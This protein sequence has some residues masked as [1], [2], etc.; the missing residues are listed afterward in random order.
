MA[1]FLALEAL[2]IRDTTVSLSLGKLG[3][4]RSPAVPS[5]ITVLG[6]PLSSSSPLPSGAASIVVEGR[7]CV[8]VGAL[9]ASAGGAR[10]IL[11]QAV[12]ASTIAWVTATWARTSF[13]TTTIVT[14]ASA[15][16]AIAVIAATTVACTAA[17]TRAASA[18]SRR[19]KD[20]V[21]GTQSSLRDFG[22]HDALFKRRRFRIQRSEQHVLSDWRSD[23]SPES[24]SQGPIIGFVNERGELAKLVDVLSNGA[25]SLTALL[26]ENPLTFKPVRW[27]A[28]VEHLLDKSIEGPL[29]RIHRYIS[30]PELGCDAGQGRL[31]H[32]NMLCCLDKPGFHVRTRLHAVALEGM[33]IW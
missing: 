23:S 33:N 16:S 12:V 17:A 20:T 19:E 32:L 28:V 24:A 9:L 10:P 5:T 11:V 3:S 15:A 6:L 8:C 22:H 1:S 18:V 31:E 26:K 13:A 21:A 14:S 27:E 29:Q 7:T 25:I 30:T 4:V 2:A